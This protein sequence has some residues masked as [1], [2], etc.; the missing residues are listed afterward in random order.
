[1]AFA[2]H[3]VVET[4]GHGL[5]QLGELVV[6]LGILTD[7]N[8]AVRVI[9]LPHPDFRAGLE[10]VAAFPITQPGAEVPELRWIGAVQLG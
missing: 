9:V 4:D 6:F 2:P 8:V 5:D 1:M 3:S 7:S 10:A